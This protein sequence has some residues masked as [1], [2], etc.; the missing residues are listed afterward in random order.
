MNICMGMAWRLQAGCSGMQQIL[1]TFGCAREP[2]TGVALA[3]AHSGQGRIL[4]HLLYIC[5]LGHSCAACECQ[6]SQAE[7]KGSACVHSC[8]LEHCSQ[9]GL[10]VSVTGGAVAARLLHLLE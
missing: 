6:L 5:R 8:A 4:S 2:S 7:A 3:G 1:C 10:S 9:L